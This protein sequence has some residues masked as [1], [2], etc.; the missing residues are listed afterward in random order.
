MRFKV[1]GFAGLRVPANWDVE[2]LRA[3]TCLEGLHIKLL[4]A[5]TKRTSQAISEPLT[6][7]PVWN[8]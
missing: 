6:L 5:E 4:S 7:V 2:S 3:L 1:L 8:P